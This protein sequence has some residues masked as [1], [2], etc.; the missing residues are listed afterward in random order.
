MVETIGW[1]EVSLLVDGELAE[2]AAEV[3]SRHIPAGVVIESTRVQTA[4]YDKGSPADLLRVYGYLPLDDQ[5]A[6]RRERIE[7]D[8]WFLGRISPLPD[9][10][11]RQ[12]WEED[13]TQVWKGQFQPALVGDRLLVMPPWAEMPPSGERVPILIN[14]GMAFGTGTHPTTRLSLEIVEGWVRPG[15]PVIDIGCGS[16]ILSIAALKLGADRALGV[17]TDPQAVS[18]AEKNAQLN[19]VADHLALG[20]GSVPSIL[21]GEWVIS[22]APLV[23]AN[24]LAPTIILL[25]SQGLDSL[26]MPGGVLGLSGILEEQEGDVVNAL[27]ASG[28][29]IVR[30]MQ[31]GDWISLVVESG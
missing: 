18:E 8:L 21:A 22:H 25:V 30:R 28:N 2:A 20:V 15:K 11:Y 13:W 7:H 12:V 16:G 1:L 17:D 27:R 9:P 4:E 23:L 26:V 6:D 19:G 29:K 31:E 10:E 14:P 5:L 3:L 24:I